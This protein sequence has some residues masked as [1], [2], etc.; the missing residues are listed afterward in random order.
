MSRKQTEINPASKEGD[1]IFDTYYTFIEKVSLKA[2]QTNKYN[3]EYLVN[4][5]TIIERNL[6]DIAHDVSKNNIFVKVTNNYID[7]ILK[8]WFPILEIFSK[9]IDFINGLSYN[10]FGVSLLVNKTSRDLPMFETLASFFYPSFEYNLFFSSN[11]TLRKIS[12]NNIVTTIRGANPALL[13]TSAFTQQLANKYDFHLSE[14][15][16]NEVNFKLSY[17]LEKQIFDIEISELV[18]DVGIEELRKKTATWNIIDLLHEYNL[19]SENE[20][21][22]EWILK[23]ST[24]ENTPNAIKFISLIETFIN[25][26]H[27]IDSENIDIQLINWG[28][29]SKWAEFKIRF[30]TFWSKEETKEILTKT[31]K[32]LQAELFDKKIGEAEKLKAEAFKTNK[33][34]ENL[35]D[36]EGAN[37]KNKLDIQ[38]RKLEVLE[39]QIEI[40]SKIEDLRAKKIDNHIKLSGMIKDGL[41]NNDTN[42]T[43]EL[44][45]M[46]YIQKENEV[47][48]EQN[49]DLID[50]KGT[51]KPN[52]ESN[53]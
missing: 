2:K 42:F 4:S 53:Q 33:E 44:N 28:N 48:I 50:G 15:E 38:M 32:A 24:K 3:Y 41:I 46:L 35:M 25:A 30:K 51:I 31:S 1:N 13:A 16:I 47:K 39:K 27:L 37:E 18:S 23:I 26:I 11:D 6:I 5:V 43:I 9:N 40:E 7:D 22:Y 8:M 12:A 49:L 20:I 34:A 10:F 19:K 17:Q 45:G 36:K 29:G 14:E 21:Q 52:S